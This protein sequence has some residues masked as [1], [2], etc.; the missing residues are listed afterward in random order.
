MLKAM[1]I[2]ECTSMTAFFIKLDQNKTYWLTAET[3][4]KPW[5]Y[6]VYLKQ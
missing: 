4:T 2:E 1:I 5:C 3:K 6:A